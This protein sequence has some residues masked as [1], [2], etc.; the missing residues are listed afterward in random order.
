MHQ[1]RAVSRETITPRCGTG[2]ST[3]R[4]PNGKRKYSHTQGRS[5]R[6]GTDALLTGTGTVVNTFYPR[7]PDEWTVPYHHAFT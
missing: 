5:L 2:S 6:S 1:R 3:S 7:L 4:E